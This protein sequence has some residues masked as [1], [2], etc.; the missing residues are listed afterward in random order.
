M[1]EVCFSIVVP[2]YK[3]EKYIEECVNSIINQDYKNFELILVDDGSP[4]NCGV[5]C[6]DY[7]RKY[8]RIS[9]IHKENGGLISAWKAGVRIAKNKYLLFVDGDDW[10]DCNLLRRLAE[11]I[12]INNDVDLIQFQF[13]C[14]CNESVSAEEKIKIY[15]TSEILDKLIYYKGYQKVITN[16]RVNKVFLTDKLKH[17]L[18]DI[19]DRVN[20]GEDKQTVFCYVLNSR[21]LLLTDFEGYYYRQNFD[22]MTN[23]Y[24]TN[25]YEKTEILFNSM[26]NMIAKYSDFDFD[27]QIKKEK[28]IFAVGILSNSFRSKDKK[29]K[30]ETFK[31]VIS[32][33]EIVGG[34]KIIPKDGLNFFCRRMMKGINKKSYA[35]IAFWQ[36][37]KKLKNNTDRVFNKFL[38]KNLR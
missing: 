2:I 20:I 8:D 7:A 30:K 16:N 33:D 23:K 17:I 26:K 10:I 3:V 11:L 5:I 1:D 13:K 27:D 19:D 32:D 14:N 12:T 6:D 18:D 31:A 4:D 24:S 21:K 36:T 37:V 38:H 9:V 22:S 29:I 28:F 34:A 35:T 15:N 25:M